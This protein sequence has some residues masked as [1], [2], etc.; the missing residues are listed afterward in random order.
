M[1]PVGLLRVL[2]SSGVR[3]WVEG[4]RLRYR[5]PAP[6]PA[7]LRSALIAHKAAI[8]SI[9]STPGVVLWSTDPTAIGGRWDRDTW[10]PPAE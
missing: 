10:I 7:D 5:S 9:L 3:L 8:L 2:G 4:D 1:T 6:L